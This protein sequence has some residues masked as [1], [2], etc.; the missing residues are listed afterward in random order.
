MSLPDT[1][2]VLYPNKQTM[3]HFI[4]TGLI[5][6]GQVKLDSVTGLYA[7]SQFLSSKVSPTL[8]TSAPSPSR[9]HLGSTVGSPKSSQ[10]LQQLA[11]L[12]S[13]VSKWIHKHVEMN[14]YVDLTPIFR[15]YEAHLH[16]I[17][18]KVGVVYGTDQLCCH[19]TT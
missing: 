5:K 3:S 13:S 16:D 6:A 7:S 17:D 4:F 15:D 2:S 9:A 10:Y 19:G 8:L 14:A 11:S 12:N 18:V 1:T